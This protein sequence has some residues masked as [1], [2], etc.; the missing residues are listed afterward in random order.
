MPEARPTVAIIG[1]S[2]DPSKYGNRS[3]LA[4]RDAGYEVYP[5]NP[6]GGE[7]EGL[8]AFTSIEEVPASPLDRV[9]MYVPPTVGIGLLEAIAS[10]GCKELWLNPGSESPEIIARAEE[11]GL[12]AIVAC[13][14]I[15]SQQRGLSS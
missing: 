2:A 9:S 6:R 7:I 5:I 10:K 3:L 15:D 13:S 11:L 14:L 4:H 8:T 1:A 12:N